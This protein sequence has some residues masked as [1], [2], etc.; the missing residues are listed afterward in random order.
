MSQYTLITGASSGIGESL[1]REYAES[2]H[3]LILTARRTDRLE[4]L[5]GELRERHGRSVEV[6][7]ADLGD[8]SGVAELADTVIAGI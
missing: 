4:K 3:D 8:P 5:A 2:G 6:V 7:S 1:A